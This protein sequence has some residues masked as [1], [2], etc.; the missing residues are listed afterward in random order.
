MSSMHLSRVLSPVTL[1]LTPSAFAERVTDACVG[2]VGVSI[3]SFVAVFFNAMWRDET[4]RIS[5]LVEKT[6]RT[7]VE[8]WV[9][10]L[11]QV[12]YL[13]SGAR[14]LSSIA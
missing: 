11:Q 8:A 6:F 3:E 1:M 12:P 9:V 2:V 7:H 14:P 4:F 13:A 10:H 5:R